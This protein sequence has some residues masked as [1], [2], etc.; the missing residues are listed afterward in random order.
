MARACGLNANFVEF[1]A[2][3]VVQSVNTSSSPEIAGPIIDDIKASLSRVVGW[4]VAQSI[5]Q[6]SFSFSFSLFFFCRSFWT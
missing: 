1:Y 5:S 3:N 2:A 6:F 4:L